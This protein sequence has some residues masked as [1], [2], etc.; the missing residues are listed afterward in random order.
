MSE[1]ADPVLP[2]TDHS[3]RV[4]AGECTA[5]YDSDGREEHRG[6]VTVV[7]KPDNTVLV[8]DADGYQPVAWLTR[9]D[10]VTCARDRGFSVTA[11]S[12]EETLRVVGHSEDGYASYPATEAGV[13]V[14]S[15]P[16]CGR[17]LV[18]A[19]GAVS[20]LGCGNRYGLPAG[21]SIRSEHCECGLPRL[22]AERGLPFDICMD[23]DCESLDAAVREEFDRAWDCPECGD[24]LR[25]LRRG[26]LIAGCDSY[27][28][29]ETGFSIP[30]GTIV[31]TCGCDLP[32][33]ETPT[34]RRCL[35]ATC[36]ASE[37]P[38]P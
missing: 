20:C 7:V 9:A 18:R 12:G 6:H 15:C 37:L 13:P 35:D 38:E 27:P 17:S 14:G 11:R 22:R 32:L 1:T 26:G 3:I 31:G 28:D 10:S 23:R 30:A 4:F 25:V 36:E 5:I 21:A 24:D 34:G 29:C 16:D 19:S 2:E 8:H 33:F